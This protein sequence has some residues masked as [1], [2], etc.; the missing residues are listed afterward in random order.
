MNVGDITENTRLR[1]AVNIALADLRYSQE[2]AINKRREVRFVVQAGAN[3]YYA[4]YTDNNETVTN[5]DGQP[6]DRT[7]NTGDYQDV[8]ISDTETSS[9]LTFSDVGR[10]DVGSGY[11]TDKSVM[12]LNGGEF[13]IFIFG[14]GLSTFQDA[15]G[16][17]C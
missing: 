13:E 12:S 6:I 17:G 3:R 11:F 2:M 5:S 10:P 4:V 9:N 8:V 15:S 7:F 1:N 16:G 14:S